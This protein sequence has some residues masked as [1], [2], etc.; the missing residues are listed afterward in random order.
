M[1]L[2]DAEAV[3]FANTDEMN[4]YM[5]EAKPLFC[6]ND[7]RDPEFDVVD[8]EQAFE[9]S[10]FLGLRLNQGVRLHALGSEFGET[11]LRDVMPALLE[12]RE[13]GLLELESDWIR[14]T[15]KGR[16]ASNEVFSRLLIASAA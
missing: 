3:R 1:L 13:A 15:A 2:R 11:M 4:A 6:R 12:V 10:L 9:E 8:R 16:I 7:E 5:G 14:L